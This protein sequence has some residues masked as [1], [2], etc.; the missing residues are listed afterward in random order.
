MRAS[1]TSRGP[2]DRES[3]ERGRGPN[4][5]ISNDGI[6]AVPEDSVSHSRSPV[7]GG[8]LTNISDLGSPDIEIPIH[9]VH[10]EHEK[11]STGRGGAGNIRDRSQSKVRDQPEPHTR[12]A[13]PEGELFYS[14]GRGGAGN[15]RSASRSR[16]KPPKEDAKP[17]DHK[18]FGVE[19]ILHKIAHPHD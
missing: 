11:V 2:E 16:S 3:L 5:I 7:R 18:P 17:H 1:S 4:R 6:D 14:S 10:P 8:G 9:V 13:K 12:L 15:I 19:N